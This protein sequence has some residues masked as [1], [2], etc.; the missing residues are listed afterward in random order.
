M[1]VLQQVVQAPECPFNHSPH[2]HLVV[3]AL[4]KGLQRHRVDMVRDE[5]AVRTCRIPNSL[6]EHT[7]KHRFES[8][9]VAS[10][11]VF[12]VLD[13]RLDAHLTSS[14]IDNGVDEVEIGQLPV[15]AVVD[16]VD[17]VERLLRGVVN[18]NSTL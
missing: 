8:V 1:Q 2:G 9:R 6:V 16:D 15:C 13:G 7:S 18:G 11:V 3:P 14:N 12:H 10:F 4:P 5:A 17:A